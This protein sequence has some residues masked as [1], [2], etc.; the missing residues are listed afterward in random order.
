MQEQGVLRL[1]KEDDVLRIVSVDRAHP[2]IRH[3]RAWPET[4]T[5]SLPIE[6]RDAD[7]DDASNE[8]IR[9]SIHTWFRPKRA[10]TDLLRTALR[11]RRL[12]GQEMLGMRIVRLGSHARKGK[13]LV[14]TPVQ[15]EI[16]DMLED[17]DIL[18]GK[19]ELGPLLMSYA[20]ARGLHNPDNRAELVRVWE[21]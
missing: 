13:G 18:L 15:E 16:V 1:A 21:N 14:L 9:V 10:A 4:L 7:G 6:S 8:P 2:L 19:S 5:H 3:H 20:S 12:R 11:L 17:R